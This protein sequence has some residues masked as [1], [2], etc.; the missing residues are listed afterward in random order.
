MGHRSLALS[1]KACE[2]NGKNV[3]P[4]SVHVLVGFHWKPLDV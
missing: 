3:S 4:M 2:E 1:E